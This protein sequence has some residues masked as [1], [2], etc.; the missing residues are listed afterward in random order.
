MT[1][2]VGSSGEALCTLAETMEILHLSESQVSTLESNGKLHRVQPASPPP[3]TGGRGRGPRIFYERSEVESYRQE[4]LADLGA[5]EAEV[6]TWFEA[7]RA[8]VE[9]LRAENERLTERL[10]RLTGGPADALRRHL[11]EL[12]QRNRELN[13]E[14]TSLRKAHRA[15]VRTARS[16]AKQ[17]VRLTEMYQKAAERPRM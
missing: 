17:L 3:R 12:E 7:R 8:E 13:E 11:D 9:E 6:L 10:A 15:A 14:L 4:Q 1:T 2:V 5:V 16:L